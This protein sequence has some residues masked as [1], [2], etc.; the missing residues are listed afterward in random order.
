MSSF[1]FQKLDI[2][3]A[4]LITSFSADDCRG[5][6]VKNYEINVFRENGIEFRC[7]ECF[8][9][10]SA[11]NVIRGMHFQLRNPQAKLVGV[12][13]GS[14]YDVF[15]DLRKESKTFGQWRGFYLTSEN[16][17]SLLIPKGCAH[18]FVALSEGSIVSYLCDGKYD[19]ETDTGVFCF[20][21]E[22]GIDWPICDKR[23]AILGERDQKLMN[24]SDF[25][26]NCSFINL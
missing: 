3:D 18:G 14:V 1:S 5:S 22:I 13:S 16:R 9:S 15:V 26:R 8:V 7:N 10:S 19:K 17:S 12:I 24:F 4:Y 6:F 11:K 21:P 25:K 2:E 23:S 20:D